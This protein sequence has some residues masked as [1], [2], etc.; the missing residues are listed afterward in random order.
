MVSGSSKITL[1]SIY[2]IGLLLYLVIPFFFILIDG[3]RSSSPHSSEI[4][5]IFFVSLVSWCLGYWCYSSLRVTRHESFLEQEA[6]QLAGNKKEAINTLGYFMIIALVIVLLVTQI[7]SLFDGFTAFLSNSYGQF[8][9]DNV[10][11]LSSSSPLL[12]IGLILGAQKASNS[13]R[14]FKL[15]IFLLIICISLLWIAGGLRNLT[16]MLLIGS[17]FIAFENRRISNILIFGSLMAMIIMT[18][19]IA[20]FRNESLISIITGDVNISRLIENSFDYTSRYLDG[21]FG[22]P[23][24]VYIYLKEVLSTFEVVPLKSYL[25]DPLL[26]LVPTFIIPDRAPT[27]A[28]QFTYAYFQS[29]T[30]PEGL[31]FSFINEAVLNFSLLFPIPIIFFAFT[32]AFISR[33]LECSFSAPSHLFFLSTAL[34]ACSLNFFRIAFALFVKF[35]FIIYISSRI[36]YYICRPLR[37]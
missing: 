10:N 20:V 37:R 26:H 8:N 7:N 29:S 23:H 9:S 31:G 32:I 13:K 30:P 5:I 24:R 27:L 36:S 14:N 28:T 17:F 34:A 18:A 33:K 22:T 1:T 35:S 21:E 15:L 11:S 19:F 25:I 12:V 6:T 4:S 16:G 3:S 2:A